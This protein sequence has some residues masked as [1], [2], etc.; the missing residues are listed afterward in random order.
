MSGAPRR[1]S[2]RG[3]ARRS[4][5]RPPGRPDQG[6]RTCPAFRYLLHRIR[7]IT[8]SHSFA[9]VTSAHPRGDV[10]PPAD[11]HP[12]AGHVPCPMKGM[13]L[14]RVRLASRRILGATATTLLAAATLTVA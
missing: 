8:F 6:H 13:T 5:D 2:G 12:P 10:A 4:P 9:R 7:E 14:M 11:G 3:P 1:P